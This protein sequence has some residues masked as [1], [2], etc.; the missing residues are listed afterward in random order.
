MALPRSPVVAGEHHD[1]VV[2]LAHGLQVAAQSA[3]VLVDVVHHPGVD[4]H[5]TGEQLP[6]DRGAVVPGA[7]LVARLGVA[8]R[9]DGA[10]ADHAQL[11]LPL[12]AL[13]PDAVPPGGVA[14]PV[15]AHVGRL[16]LQRGVGRAVG[17][18]QEE[19]LGGVRGPQLVDHGRGL[20]GEVVGE[21]V[22]VGVAVHAHVVVVP[23]QP[24]GLVVVGEGVEDAVEAV[25]A[26]LEGP[27]VF[28]GGVAEVGVLGEVPLARHQGG[29]AVVPEDLGHGDGVVPQFV[30]VAG[31]AG[32]AVDDVADPGHVGVEPGHQRRPGGRAHGVD[33]EVGVAHALGGQ[34]VQLGGGDLGPVAAQV[35]VAQVV[36]Q[37]DHHVGGAGG[38]PGR[39]RPVGLR[40]GEDGAHLPAEPGIRSGRVSGSG[41][42]DGGG[43]GGGRGSG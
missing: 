21:V 8:G 2:P 15:G 22:A 27:G 40:G 28:G 26:P 14:A 12:E 20:V 16:G 11:P 34:P 1:G 4:L 30:G 5:V 9:Q 38:G 3:E 13:G 36:G 23:A 24:V 17:E 42:G 25:E 35:G 6:L 19:R 10:G 37:H 7:D 32:V 41:A 43:V 29:P 33:V 31:E 39:R 18:V